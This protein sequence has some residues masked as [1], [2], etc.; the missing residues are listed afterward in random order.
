MANTTFN[1]ISLYVTNC[2]NHRKAQ[3]FCSKLTIYEKVV[4]YSGIKIYSHLITAI[5]DLS[6]NKNKFK[7]AL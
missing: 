2:V 3:N 5:K 7:L 4:C 6:G 1:R